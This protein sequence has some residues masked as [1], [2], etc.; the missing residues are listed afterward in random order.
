VAGINT[1][2]H[3]GFSVQD[4]PRAWRFYEKVLGGK[5][6]HISN[7]NHRVYEGWPIISF[8]EMG[9]HRFELC[10]AQEELPEAQ[11]GYPRIGFAVTEDNFQKLMKELDE[12]D[13]A[14]EGPVT[15]PDPVPLKQTLRVRDPEGN[16]LEFS[17]RRA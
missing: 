12:A 6:T 16:L 5:P 17:T 14:Y 7:L 4:I 1:F 3:C 13:I 8:V 10:L 15:Y 11:T 2:D 9:G